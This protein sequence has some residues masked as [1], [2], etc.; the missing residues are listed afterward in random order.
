[1]FVVEPRGHADVVRGLWRAAAA[2]RLAHALSFEGA[3]GIGKFT[4]AKWFV[5]GLL[6]REGPPLGEA[7]RPCG[8]CPSCKKVLAGDRRG[9]H[10]D[11]YVLDAL[12]DERNEI[13][14]TYVRKRPTPDAKDPPFTIEEFLS[15]R[16]SESA[17]RALVVRDAELLNPNAQNALLKT[18]E[19]PTPGTTLVLATSN[20]SALLPTVRSRLLRV[21]L[22]RLDDADTRAV[23]LEARERGELDGD[24]DLDALVALARGAPGAAL[25]AAREGHVALRELLVEVACGAARPHERLEALWQVPGEF[26]GTS[27]GAKD[28]ERTRAAATLA[29]GIVVDLE[30]LCGG[31]H[32]VHHP[33]LEH[34]L[35]ERARSA[36]R[37]ALV[38]ARE[39]TFAAIGDVEL[40]LDAAAAMERVVRALGALAGR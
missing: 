11:L 18:L 16:P 1:V 30:R 24:A 40:N 5:M 21:A 39:A 15:L 25:R 23:A 37:G 2:E 4:A 28:R 34:R 3:E 35:V 12:A 33:D 27:A 19:E 13:V 38:A 6:C 32:A 36:A 14:V 8:A 9:I 17:R 7:A 26:D 31:L 20:P 10:P 29:A 22:T